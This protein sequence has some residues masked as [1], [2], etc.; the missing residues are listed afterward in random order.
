MSPYFRK[1]TPSE[2]GNLSFK[3]IFGSYSFLIYCLKFLDPFS[4]V[5]ATF[6]LYTILEIFSEMSS[7][8]L[9]LFFKHFN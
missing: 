6:T 4:Y 9:F 3:I 1:E 7:K 5:P 8:Y 2:L